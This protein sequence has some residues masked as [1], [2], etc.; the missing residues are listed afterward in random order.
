MYKYKIS[1]SGGKD[2]V[3]SVILWYVYHKDLIPETE[4]VFYEPMF[5]KNVSGLLDEQ[6]KHIYNTLI[7]KFN[8]WGFKC[9]ILKS[10]ITYVE[11]YTHITTRSKV[12][13][14]NGKMRGGLIT[15]ACVFT[16]NKQ[17][18]LDKYNPNAITIIGIAYDEPKRYA[19]LNDKQYS[20][21]YQHKFTEIDAYNLCESWGLLSPHYINGGKR[22]GCWFC[23]NKLRTGFDIQHHRDL[24]Y[25][26]WYENKG[27]TV[28]D[29]CTYKMTFTEL[30]EKF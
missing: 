7:P 4:V 30:F 6:Y 11:S 19:R 21:L 14:R 23:P 18:T 2:S 10:T 8:N 12:L 24:L 26:L 27:K 13:E 20:I 1:C 25:K 29:K 15:G 28:S 9:T 3:A 17:R 22:D 5:D 16:S